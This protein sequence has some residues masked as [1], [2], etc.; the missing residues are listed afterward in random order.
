[1]NG[2]ADS[3]GTTILDFISDENTVLTVGG[4]GAGATRLGQEKAGTPN[5]TQV[6]NIEYYFEPIAAECIKEDR[7]V[8]DPD[9]EPSQKPSDAPEGEYVLG[10]VD[11]NKVVE[12]ADAQL[13]LK[14]AL[15]ID[16]LEGNALKAADVHKNG[17]IE[18]NDAQMILK[19]ALKIIDSFE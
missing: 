3:V 11:G 18:L 13:A 10:D 9:A 19:K 8:L 12:L 4:L 14:A 1:M 5:G 17:S 16:I 15:K 6:K 2:G 7:I